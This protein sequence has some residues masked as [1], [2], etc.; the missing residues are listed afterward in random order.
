MNN[1]FLWS[2]GSGYLVA[3]LFFSL[4]NFIG[5]SFDVGTWYVLL[6]IFYEPA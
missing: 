5:K 6:D 3:W 1:F 4:N 2:Y